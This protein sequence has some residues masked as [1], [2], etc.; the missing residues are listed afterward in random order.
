MLLLLSLEGTAAPR[1]QTDFGQSPLPPR[2]AITNHKELETFM[3]GLMAAQTAAHHLSGAVVCVVAGGQ[4]I[5]AKGYGYA[6]IAKGTRVDPEKTLFRIGSVS[7]LFVWTAVMQL[8][9]QGKLDLN[10]DVNSYLKGIRIP[11]TYHEPITMAHLMSHTAGFE[12]SVI[13]LFAG[14]PSQLRPLVEILSREMPMRVRPPGLLASYSNH[15]SALA[16]LIVEDVSGTDWLRYL[17]QKIL[18]PLGMKHTTGRQP[19]P[20][21]L[22]GDLAV[23]YQFSDGDF[24]PQGFEYVPLAPAGSMS[25]SAVDM[26]RFM[27]AHL[28]NGRLGQAHILSESSARQMRGRLFTHDPRLNGM[29]HGFMEMS[30]NGQKIIG[31]GGD[32]FLFHTILLLL[33]ECNTGLFASYSSNTGGTARNE[34][35]PAFLNHYYPA[36]PPPAAKASPGHKIQ[37]GRFSGLYAPL[38]VSHTSLAKIAL[39]I[40]NLRVEALEDGRLRT[41]GAGATPKL[42]V[43]QESMLFREVG[44]SNLMAFR[45]DDNGR[46]TYLFFGSAPPIAFARLSWFEHP[47]FHGV[48]A[49]TCVGLIVSG[50]VLWPIL[51]IRN[52]GRRLVSSPPRTARLLGWL[53]GAALV[54]FLAGTATILSNP[55]QIAFGVPATLRHLL[56]LPLLAIALCMGMMLFTLLAWYRRYWHFSGRLHYT[57]VTFATVG[58]LLWLDYWNLIGFRF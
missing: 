36:Q 10:Q 24:K 13:G 5:L 37:D 22:A 11:P 12:E 55:G 43:E 40:T 38:R 7:K 51:A 28:Q 2:P 26:G 19:V 20:A 14:S 15:G 48:L 54:S 27:I 16:G 56:Y 23:G 52:F 30:Q 3:D 49:G 29:L 47:A 31:H 39:L 57:L 34:L 18:E 6:D 17:E 45:Q 35:V 4:V 9:E 21:A 50:L 53:A 44:G 42:W 8:V 25:A 33:P 58:L 41:S 1:L 32:T 46:I